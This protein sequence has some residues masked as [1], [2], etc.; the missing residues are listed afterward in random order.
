MEIFQ[1]LGVEVEALWREKNYNE[2]LL[3]AIAA[4]ALTEFDIPT[5]I[6]PWEVVTW[7][8]NQT[9]L[10]GQQ[11]LMGRFSDVPV[12]IARFPRFHIDVYFWYNSTTAIHQHGFCGAF[13]VFEGSSIHSTYEFRPTEKFNFFTEIGD[14]NLHNVE[15]LNKG[16]IREIADGRKFIHALFH[17]DNPSVTLIIRT[18]RSPLSSP[19][20]S[21]LPPG[22]AIDPFFEEPN[23][24]KK[25]QTA[26][27]L[28][29]LKRADAD[30][31]IANLLKASDAQMS[32][33][34]LSNIKRFYSTSQAEEIFSFSA[35]NDR[36]GNLVNVVQNKH[37]EIAIL[38][39]NAIVEQ[40]KIGEISHKRSIVTNPD[41]RFFLAVLMN[42]SE[43]E[44]VFSLVKERFPDSDPLD[45]VLDWTFDLSTTKTFGANM[46]NAL[47][48]AD[49]DDNDLMALEFL[50]KDL[51]EAGIRDSL[52]NDYGLSDTDD[53]LKNLP[54]RN[55]K[56]RASVVLQ[57]LINSN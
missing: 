7:I 2:D 53:W 46:T 44:R 15:L 51:D 50:L 27:M 18:H 52:K 39:A 21:Y 56:L 11:D 55:E 36:F 24:I 10:P 14:L 12:T 40:E 57:A 42:V 22:V 43:R 26:S 23:F 35:N 34:I 13:Q 28:L 45:K 8:M 6:S 37:G 16:G 25:L 1:K 19:Q 33:L 9:E 5:K 32:Y 4:K 47:G 30:E 38:F 17:L 29:H 3:P 31:Q 48:I 54:L 20:F 41:L 49:F